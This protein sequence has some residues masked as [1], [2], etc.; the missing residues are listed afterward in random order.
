MEKKFLITINNVE[1]LTAVEFFCSF[2]GSD[3]KHHVTLL[4]ICRP[5][6]SNMS[7]RL[8][9]MWE[10]PADPERGRPSVEARKAIERS[11]QL[12]ES[13]QIPIDQV[14]TKTMGERFGIVHDILREGAAGLYDAIV[15]GKRAS[16]ALQWLV[17]RKGDEIAQSIIKDSKLETPIWVCP[18]PERDRC[19]VLIG[20]DGSEN[21]MRAVDHVGF[22][23]SP[24]DRHNITLV[25][26]RTGA[27]SSSH[28]IFHQAEG[29]L[30]GHDIADR[31]IETVSTW[32]VSVA[33]TIEGILKRHRHAAVAVG[34]H[35]SQGGFLKD[36]KLAGRT[37]SAL[38]SRLEDASIWCCP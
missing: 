33:G 6:S 21:S 22:I 7:A 1:N 24:H 19:N 11:L 5:E 15:L 27:G 32:G 16:Y 36:V 4:H 35:G 38:I 28:D 8:M 9:E 14:I 29:I 20:V 34:L 23:V 26:V 18:R 37:T 30:R 2:F 25:H 31:R 17:E 12:L 13:N 3:A 10:N